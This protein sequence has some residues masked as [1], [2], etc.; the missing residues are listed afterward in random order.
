MHERLTSVRTPPNRGM[1]RA[2]QLSNAEPCSDLA[3]LQRVAAGIRALDAGVVPGLP[4]P[5]DQGLVSTEFER[6]VG[7]LRAADIEVARDAR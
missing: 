1:G 7:R 6:A 4:T 3:L 2:V 5:G